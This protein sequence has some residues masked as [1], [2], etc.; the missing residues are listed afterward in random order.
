MEN[1]ILLVGPSKTSSTSGGDINT[2]IRKRTRNSKMTK[3]ELHR[4]LT[5]HTTKMGRQTLP[6]TQGGKTTSE[7]NVIN[8]RIHDYTTI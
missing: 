3:K 2:M 1:D 8:K 6:Y 7:N 4:S 5:L